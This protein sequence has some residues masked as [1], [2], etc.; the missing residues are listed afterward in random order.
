MLFL[1]LPSVVSF[2]HSIEEHHHEDSCINESDTHIHKKELDCCLSQVIIK[3][4]NGVFIPTKD[5]LFITYQN[6]SQKTTLKH[7]IY[8]SIYRTTELRGPPI[9]C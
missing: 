4:N 8:T 6:I 5:I 7:T 2:A 1:L 9:L 3:N